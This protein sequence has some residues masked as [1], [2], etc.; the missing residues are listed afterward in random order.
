MVVP[1]ILHHQFFLIVISSLVGLLRHLVSLCVSLTVI[2]TMPPHHHAVISGL[3][4][5]N[6]TPPMWLDPVILNS[7]PNPELVTIGTNFEH[8]TR[9][10]V[11]PCCLHCTK[12]MVNNPAL[13][14][15]HPAQWVN[16]LH[17][18]WQH[19]KCHNVS[20]PVSILAPL[21]HCIGPEH[22]FPNPVPS[23]GGGGCL[24]RG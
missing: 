12:A 22:L 16:C 24:A 5:P 17:C 1:P 7:I 18:Y 14:C 21:I 20:A 13:M 8:P 3:V 4:D 2:F 6:A 9:G 10:L 11:H 23:A 15:C 19:D